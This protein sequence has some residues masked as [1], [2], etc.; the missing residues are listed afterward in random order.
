MGIGD[1]R[2]QARLP[3]AE[4]VELRVLGASKSEPIQAILLNLS[5]GGAALVADH[6]ICAGSAV[7]VLWGDTLLLGE[8]CYCAPESGRYRLGL[9][10]RH[11]LSHLKDLE[12]L[13]ARLLGEVSPPTREP[14]THESALPE[15][16]GG[17]SR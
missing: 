16:V 17:R 9:Q 8:V 2:T 7:R 13:R 11:S 3:M 12:R 4:P 6:A 5:E 14:A 15:Q 1:K 10:L